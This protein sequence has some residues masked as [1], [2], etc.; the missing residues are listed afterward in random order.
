MP[1]DSEAL[2]VMREKVG[3]RRERENG[4]GDGDGDAER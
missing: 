2:L 1:A 3:W 4:D